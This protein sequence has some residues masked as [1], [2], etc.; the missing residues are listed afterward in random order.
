MVQKAG[1]VFCEIVARESPAKIRYED[2]EVIVIDNVLGWTPVMLLV[3]PKRHMS[4]GEVW[5]SGII[6]R[7]GR[8]A[9]DMGTQFCPKGYRLLSNFG[10]DAMQSQEHG[11]L[12][13]LGG[14]YLGPYA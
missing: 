6:S 10:G 2:D 11:H 4:Q 12:H 1:C 9:I 5:S 7:I 8:V 14:M 3:M 13:V